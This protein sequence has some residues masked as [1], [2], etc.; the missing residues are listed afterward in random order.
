MS[1]ARTEILRPWPPREALHTPPRAGPASTAIREAQDLS[2]QARVAAARKS[3]AASAVGNEQRR[4][5]GESRFATE[6]S[7]HEQASG[8]GD[9]AGG[10]CFSNRPLAS[11]CPVDFTR[12]G[13]CKRCAF[14][15]AQQEAAYDERAAA[16]SPLPMSKCTLTKQVGRDARYLLLSA[17]L[18][19][20]ATWMARGENE[21]F[22]P[23]TLLPPQG[24][25]ESTQLDGRLAT[26]FRP[27]HTFGTT[28]DRRRWPRRVHVPN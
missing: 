18:H 23:R 19:H 11:A 8:D 10:F 13:S 25:V 4:I 12:F 2:K 6:R 28:S 17:D 1:P 20:L 22:C 16:R 7:A 26:R 9:I 21:R 3:L 14:A 27:C 5:A 24:F 15:V